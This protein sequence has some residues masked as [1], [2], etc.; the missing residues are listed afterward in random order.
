MGRFIA[1]C[2]EAA[3]ATVKDLIED[4][5]DLSREMAPV[6]V[7]DDPRTI[8]LAQSIETRM[9]S[10]TA[11]VWMATARHALP[12]ELG[13]ARHDITGNVKFWWERE[14]RWWKPGDNIIDHPGNAPQPYL[15]PAYEIIMARAMQ[16]A[17]KHYPG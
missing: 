2:E 13:A 9:L 17:R 16:V 11:G 15:R 3:T 12:I 6:G 7:K 14:A 1:R 10:S 8:P 4:G 5:A